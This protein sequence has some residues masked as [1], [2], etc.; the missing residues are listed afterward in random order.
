MHETVLRQL[1]MLRAIPRSPSRISVKGILDRLKGDGFRVS[2]RTVQ[3]D[4]LNLSALFGITYDT[5]GRTQWWYYSPDA[6]GSNIPGMSPAEALVFHLSE[7]YLRSLLP[8]GQVD[9]IASYF[10]RANAVLDAGNEQLGQWRERVAIIQR[11]PKLGIPEVRPEVMREVHEALLTGQKLQLSYHRRGESEFRTYKLDVQGMVLREGLV[12]IVAVD[13]TEERK[14]IRHFALHRAESAK[15]LDSPA[16]LTANFN[17]E[18]H[19]MM[20]G[21]FTTA[22]LSHQMVKLVMHVD[23]RM[24]DHLTERRLSDD[25]TTRRLTKEENGRHPWEVRATVSRNEELFWW[26]RGFG[27]QIE[28]MGPA[29]LREQ[30]ARSFKQAARLYAQQ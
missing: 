9:Q 30:F 8:Q 3:R 29:S 20:T 26:L 17:L 10:Q 15:V 11:G 14:R 12:Y 6:R 18:T 22:D 13:T 1:S 5:E 19:L 24:Y 28:V 23:Q 16:E 21:M 7:K 27:E 2:A 4:L 25:Q